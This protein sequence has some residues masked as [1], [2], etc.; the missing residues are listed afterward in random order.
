MEIQAPQRRKITA[1]RRDC[2]CL[3]T[4]EEYAPNYDDLRG[5]FT[6]YFFL[7]FHIFNMS[8]EEG[9]LVGLAVGTAIFAKNRLDDRKLEN[10]VAG[11]QAI[12]A[13]Q[14]GLKTR[15]WQGAARRKGVL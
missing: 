12:N 1:R 11:F 7:N 3:V 9:G 5:I 14:P 8:M 10:G 6:S 13:P 4:L 2:S 15:F